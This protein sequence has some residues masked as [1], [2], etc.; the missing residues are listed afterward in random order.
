MHHITGDDKLA[1]PCFV[2]SSLFLNAF[3]CTYITSKFIFIRGVPD[4]YI[5]MHVYTPD[6]VNSAP[7]NST[8]QI[9]GWLYAVV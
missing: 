5:D 9:L 4:M 1:E 6:E 3:H 7:L 8:S 2:E